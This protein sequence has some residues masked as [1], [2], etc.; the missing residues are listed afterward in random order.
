MERIL[1]AQGEAPEMPSAMVID[2]RVCDDAGVRRRAFA[3]LSAAGTHPALS[4]QQRER[5]WGNDG[6]RGGPSRQSNYAIDGDGVYLQGC[7]SDTDRAGRRMAY[8]Y[9]AGGAS[10]IDDAARML[11][12]DSAVVGR[13]CDRD[14]LCAL[15]ALHASAKKK[16]MIMT[17]CAVC[18]A[19]SVIIVS[20]IWLIWN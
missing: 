7:Y 9:Y 12:E 14:E 10:G 15:A 2:G 5:L 6:G 11:L 16:R 13:H 18:T 20:V 17:A 3:R 19:A 1:W 8:M 4:P